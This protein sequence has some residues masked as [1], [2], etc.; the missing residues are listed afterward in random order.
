KQLDDVREQLGDIRE[1]LDDVRKQLDDVR[2]QLGDIREQLDDI[3]EQLDDIRKQLD[4]IRDQLD[5]IRE[6]LD[7]IREQLG[8]IREQLDGIE[9]EEE[10]SGFPSRLSRA[11]C[12]WASVVVPP[13]PPVPSVI[14]APPVIPVLPPP[15]PPPGDRSPS[16][17]RTALFPALRPPLS[18]SFGPERRSVRPRRDQGPVVAP[19]PPRGSSPVWLRGIAWAAPGPRGR[20][21]RSATRNKWSGRLESDFG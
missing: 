8:D 15:P 10:I 5:D 7:G 11:P 18:T 20:C 4:D 12:F 13:V 14:P 2:K 21:S 6:Q 3:R 19:P 1:Q 9:D 17:R 16:A